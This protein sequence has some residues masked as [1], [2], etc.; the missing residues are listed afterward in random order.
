MGEG[1]AGFAAEDIRAVTGAGEVL[2]AGRIGGQAGAVGKEL[3]E[4]DGREFRG[5]SLEEG[6]KEFSDGVVPC[7]F[8]VLDPC[9]EEGGGH[10]LGHG[11]EVP[12]VVRGCRV[13]GPTFAEAADA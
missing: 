4:R 13:I 8:A 10:G 6:C 2:P 7:E 3:A 1:F 9:G 11:A 5:R 12:E